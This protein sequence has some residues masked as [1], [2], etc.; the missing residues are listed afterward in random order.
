[1]DTVYIRSRFWNCGDFV[2]LSVILDLGYALRTM[3]TDK[4]LRR[5]I[6]FSLKKMLLFF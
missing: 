4:S 5:P 2:G 6:R 1:M 3:K